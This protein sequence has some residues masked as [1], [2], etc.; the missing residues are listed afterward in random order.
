[1]GPI[2]RGYVCLEGDLAR[3]RAFRTTFAGEMP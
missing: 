2:I 3:P 1:M